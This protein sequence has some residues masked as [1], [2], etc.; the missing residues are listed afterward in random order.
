MSQAFG[1]GRVRLQARDDEIRQAL[2]SEARSVRMEDITDLLEDGR[3]DIVEEML[4]YEHVQDLVYTATQSNNYVLRLA[5]RLGATRLVD[6][7][8]S[9]QGG[10]F[11]SD[12]PHLL[13]IFEL[14][15]QCGHY[16]IAL[17]FIHAGALAASSLFSSLV[18]TPDS[19]YNALELAIGEPYSSGPEEEAQRS[20]LVLEILEG[21]QGL[22]SYSPE[23]LST[24]LPRAVRAGRLGPLKSLLER[25]A[26]LSSDRYDL[27]LDAI[28]LDNPDIVRC[29]L[30]M[31]PSI[32]LDHMVLVIAAGYTMPVDRNQNRLTMMEMLVNFGA[33]INSGP[34]ANGSA[35]TMAITSNDTAMTHWLLERGVSLANNSWNTPRLHRR[36]SHGP[37]S[38]VPGQRRASARTAFHFIKGLEM[39]KLLT[40]WGLDVNGS[41]T[42]RLLP[43]QIMAQPE[44]CDERMAMLEFILAGINNINARN[45]S[46]QTALLFCCE[47]R[48]PWTPE[49]MTWIKRLV[50]SGANVMAASESGLDPLQAVSLNA[51]T[52][53]D[54]F[55][56]IIEDRTFSHAEVE[57]QSDAS[58]ESE[59]SDTSVEFFL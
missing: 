8:V 42:E 54:E 11:L 7:I 30:I 15:C 55:R 10:V 22:P 5:V 9:I 2:A 13:T 32:A 29:V 50:E 4:E 47:Y 1:R 17:R 25:G 45:E 56:A 41:S 26:R 14:A 28:R 34:F 21:I 12:H 44:L 37:A 3:A 51:P 27:L 48:G 58:D 57:V 53:F 31:G 38:T 43:I 46:G 24:H 39:L 23:I 52:Q 33:P 59:S 6:S 49:R 35:L 36:R 40:S 16:E 19:K 18:S 20:L